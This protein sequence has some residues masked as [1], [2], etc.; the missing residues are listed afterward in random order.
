MNVL[1]GRK[2]IYGITMV[3]G[4]LVLGVWT[5]CIPTTLSGN[6]EALEVNQPKTAA[7]ALKI[8]TTIVIAQD[9]ALNV[10]GDVASIE[11]VVPASVD[12]HTFQGPSPTQIQAIDDADLLISM[13]LEDI[14]PWLDDTLTALGANAPPV[15][16][17]V[18]PAMMKP[19]PGL[20]GELNPHVW[21]NPNNVKMMA[22]DTATELIA[23]APA[24]ASDIQA[25]NATYQA[26]LD[27]LLSR[28]QGNASV[29]SGLKVVSI[30]AAFIDLFRLLGVNQV[31]ILEN[32][33][34]QE[35]SQTRID[36]F[37]NLMRTENVT[38]LT[39]QTDIS[40][41]ESNA[42]A[43]A[44]GA[45]VATLFHVPGPGSQAPTGELLNSYIEVM[46]YNLRALGNPVTPPSD[47]Y[48]IYIV[49]TVGAG[50]A[51]AVVFV[52]LKK[53]RKEIA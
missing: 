26:A 29:F 7:P 34:G 42:I 32:V 14:E 37:I 53:K 13:G 36:Q 47:D 50:A 31:A 21:M 24:N 39:T 48:T 10:A 44:G 19:D 17:L 6:I 43:R 16:E 2:G 9:I 15:L 46:D 11:N 38:I 22:N 41:S 23:L 18:K 4:L 45:K 5:I 30:H 52:V 49:L 35:P 3:F 20:G 12:I 33:E 1:R 8:V 40:V 25:N 28:I 51:I 27:A